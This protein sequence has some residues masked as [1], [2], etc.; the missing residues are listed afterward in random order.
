L[1]TCH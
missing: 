1:F